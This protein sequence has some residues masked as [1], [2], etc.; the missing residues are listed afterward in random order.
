MG[1]CSSKPET[2]LQQE[3]QNPQPNPQVPPIVITK[4]QSI[5]S[6]ESLPAST[7]ANAIS[8][9][10]QEKT[11]TE[12]DNSSDEQPPT[13]EDSHPNTS[14]IQDTKPVVISTPPHI[15][16]LPDT[17]YTAAAAAAALPN[18]TTHNN[19]NTTWTIL[20]RL[21]NSAV[22]DILVDIPTTAPFLTVS[23]LKKKIPIEPDQNIKL[24]HLGRILQDDFKLVPSNT[25]INIKNDTIKVSNRGVI[26]AMIYKL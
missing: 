18:H 11:P 19:T 5:T 21:S 9:Q 26:Q 20:V 23:D 22:K 24:I 13:F 10:A 8:I 12:I 2:T 1:C 16:S 4:A 15:P 17:K 14:N 25:S 3:T 7:S 6:G